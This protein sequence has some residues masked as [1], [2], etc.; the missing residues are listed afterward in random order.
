MPNILIIHLKRFK[1]TRQKRG[2]IRSVI[3][4]P[5]EDLDL[6]Q[7]LGHPQKAKPVY[8]LFAISV[9]QFS[10]MKKVIIINS[11][12][13]VHWAEGITLHM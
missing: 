5:V 6:S 8:D 12:M 3:H 1:F 7:Y 13:K 4:F 11:V 9:H 2:K 10:L